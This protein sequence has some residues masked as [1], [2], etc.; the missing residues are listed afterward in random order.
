MVKHL[1]TLETPVLPW[2][3]NSIALTKPTI[4]QQLHPSK[5]NT[6]RMKNLEKVRLVVVS[7]IRARSI[8]ASRNKTLVHSTSTCAS[9]LHQKMIEVQVQTRA[10]VLSVTTTRC[11]SRKS[12]RKTNNSSFNSDGART[13]KLNS[14]FSRLKLVA[15]KKKVTRQI[16]H[17]IWIKSVCQVKPWPI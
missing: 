15:K 7:S 13:S 6:S 12:N 2:E 10:Q 11:S 1:R 5:N 17:T 16:N 14:K 9:K 3:R 4:T 8:T